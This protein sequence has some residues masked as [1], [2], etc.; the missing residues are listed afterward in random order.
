MI[1]S[2]AKHYK[3]DI[4]TPFN[5]LDKH[6]RKIILFGSGKEKIEFT[7]QSFKNRKIKVQKQHTFE[8]IIPNLDR[9]YIETESN[10]V[11]EELGKFLNSQ[12]CP[13]CD[14]TRLNQSARNVFINDLTLPQISKMSVEMAKEYFEKITINGWRAT[15]AEKITKEISSRLNFLSDVGLD[16]LSI[17]RSADT[18]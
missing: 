5:E 8:G 13:D 12:I 7:Y 4:E 3:F 9:R 14:G 17:N 15:I 2:I 6:I 18:L 16:Y 10:A 11:R 1:Q